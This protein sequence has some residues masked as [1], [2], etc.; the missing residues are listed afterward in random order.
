MQA[1]QQWLQER[2]PDFRPES[3]SEAGQKIL[4]S[5]SEVKWESGDA[6]KGRKLFERLACAKCHGGRRALGPDLTGVAKR[7]SRDDLFAAIV[8]PNRD[9]SARYQ[10][11]SIETK[12]GTVFTGLIVYESV[13][14]LLLRDADHKTYRIEATEIESKHL[15]RNS[16]MPSGLLKETQPADLADL[17]KYLQQL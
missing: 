12:A 13:D 11:T 10:T 6:E 16:L 8:E 14:G 15:Q 7:F 3:S 5:L 17:Y 9:I 2:Y 1:W 4:A